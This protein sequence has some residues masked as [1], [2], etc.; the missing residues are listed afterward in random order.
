MILILKE[1][2]GQMENTDCLH[3]VASAILGL[4]A[5]VMVCMKF[6]YNSILL[7]TNM[8]V[9]ETIIMLKKRM[10]T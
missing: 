8:T 2:D 9:T 1:E 5:D 10:K 6:V 3:N 4:V 7:S